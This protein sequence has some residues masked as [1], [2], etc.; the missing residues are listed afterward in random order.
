[1]G[2][3]S[4][5]FL[6]SQGLAPNDVLI[7]TGTQLGK[8][9]K[10]CS[11]HFNTIHTI[12]L[13][14][15]YYHESKKRL[16]KFTNINCHHGSSPVV[17]RKVIDPTR[18]TTIFL[19]AHFVATDDLP[20]QVQN[21]CPLLWELCAIFSFRWKAPMSVVIDDAHMH[22]RSFWK[23]RRARGYDREQWPRAE[24]LRATAAQFGFEMR[25]V[26]DVFII[27]KP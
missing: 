20:N 24:T 9:L 11:P 16:A 22:Q 2:R 6:E 19:D 13:D 7:Q 12:E 25:H 17:L 15:R 10:Y 23:L 21:Q 18:A 8:G 5:K 26:G 14:D 27:E 3:L 1:M 4:H